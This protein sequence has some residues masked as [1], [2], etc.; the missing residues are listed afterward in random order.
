MSSK[1]ARTALWVK[2]GGWAGCL[3]EQA[4][5]QGLRAPLAGWGDRTV[6]T[7]FTSV[8]LNLQEAFSV[9][10]LSL[11]LSLSH[12]HTHTHTHT[13]LPFTAERE[14]HKSSYPETLVTPA[15]NRCP[16]C[17]CWPSES[18]LGWQTGVGRDI[19]GKWDS[20]RSFWRVQEAEQRELHK[21]PADMGPLLYLGSWVLPS[22]EAASA[23]PGTSGP[24]ASV[25]STQ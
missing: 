6:I 13:L 2:A 22:N 20:K 23:T 8:S 5:G 17:W 10:S 1:V 11:S 4:E 25:F 14:T 18:H 24:R 9:V 3:L 19:S 16:A 7:E 15:P 12:T 21:N